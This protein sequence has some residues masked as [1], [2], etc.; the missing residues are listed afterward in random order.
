MA[1]VGPIRPGGG[2][3]MNLSVFC[4]ETSRQAYIRTKGV[5]IFI[6]YLWLSRKK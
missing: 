6:M 5:T 2:G 4:P 3:E 1:Q